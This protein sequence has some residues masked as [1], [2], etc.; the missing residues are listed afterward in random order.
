MIVLEPFTTDIYQFTESVFLSMLGLEIQ[1]AEAVMPSTELITGAIYYAG[2]WKEPRC[3]NAN[4]VKP[5]SSP[6]A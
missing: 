1:P 6:R 2:P 3:Y 5:T 4:R